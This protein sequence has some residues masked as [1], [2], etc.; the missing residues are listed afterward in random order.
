KILQKSSD[1]ISEKTLEIV[2]QH[3]ERIDGTGYPRGLKGKQ[4]G[5]YSRICIIA[6][7][8]DSLTTNHSYREAMPIVDALALMKERKGEFDGRLLSEF[9]KIASLAMR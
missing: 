2:L 8:F 4:I 9:V 6:N 5:L 7:T 1:R 3:H